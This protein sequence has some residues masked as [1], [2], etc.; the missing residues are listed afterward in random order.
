[1]VEAK[2]TKKTGKTRKTNLF[3][4]PEKP[5]FLD[6]TILDS[7]IR[8]LFQQITKLITTEVM[9]SKNEK[10][11]A[12]DKKTLGNILRFY[13]GK[14]KIAKGSSV[15]SL[16]M[17]GAATGQV[18]FY[19]LFNNG[20]EAIVKHCTRK[21]YGELFD[22]VEEAYGVSGDDAIK[23]QIATLVF[24]KLQERA[25]KKAVEKATGGDKEGH[26]ELKAFSYHNMTPVMDIKTNQKVLFNTKEKTVVHLAGYASYDEWLRKQTQ[27]VKDAFNLSFTPAMIKFN[28]R[29]SG[30]AED[31][32]TEDGQEI[33]C[34]NSHNLPHW[35]RTE[36]EE[37]K[38]PKEFDELM[39]HLFPKEKS[40]HYVYF[41]IYHMLDSRS[42][43]HLL[44]HG[45][46][47]IG[48]NTLIYIL[49]GLVGQSNYYYVPKDFFDNNFN[50]ELRHKRLLYFDE[51]RINAKVNEA[52]FKQ[53]HEPML[54]YHG[55]GEQ[56]TGHEQ[57]HA[58]H[59]ISNNIEVT[60]HLVYES[61]RF[62]VP[63]LTATP[64]A[65]GLGQDWLDNIHRI[66][67]DQDF[68]ANLG[69]WVLKNYDSYCEDFV[70]DAPYKSPL[71]H[72]IVNK[73]LF[74]WQK[75]L[76][77]TIESRQTDYISIESNQEEGALMDNRG[78]TVGRS[79]IENFL[80]SHKDSNDRPFAFIKQG[81][82]G[83]YICPADDYMPDIEGS[84]EET[85]DGNFSD[86]EF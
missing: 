61:R 37:P 69:W 17:D 64:I 81:T 59:V 1:M 27:E 25:H 77:E 41:W 28:P 50:S 55:K 16:R 70:K 5:K 83:R 3:N 11:S 86:M 9:M 35:R 85:D 20:Q 71:F 65:E 40:R 26:M 7:F 39:Q 54:S 52:H 19:K 38:L 31:M 10:F 30:G 73:A 72:E 63:E 49:E 14:Y 6:L 29:E 75:W 8:F 15:T 47:G 12:S 4:Q 84:E 22:S 24:V 57:N 32:T 62:G 74:P 60:N 43:V 33:T 13:T 76:I 78:V 48:K 46:R 34:I 42:S 79:K 18:A 67:Q 51:H 23:K 2:S 21:A 36:L 45:H 68:L 44:M 82:T 66:K 58:S 80:S 53:Y 56:I